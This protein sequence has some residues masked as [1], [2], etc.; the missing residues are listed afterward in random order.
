MAEPT[1][2]D[3][4]CMRTPAKN[5]QAGAV[6]PANRRYA[7]D[8]APGALGFVHDLLNT[9]SAGRPRQPDLLE[10]LDS[11]Q[12]WLDEAIAAWAVVSGIAAQRIDLDEQS[13]AALRGFRDDLHANISHSHNKSGGSTP[14]ALA[15]PGATVELSVRPDGEIA[16]Q[17]RGSGWRYVAAVALSTA[18]TGQSDGS[19]SRLKTCRNPRCQGAFYDRSRNNSGVWHDL[20]ACGMPTNTRAHRARRRDDPPTE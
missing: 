9:R 5:D 15:V 7:V 2:A 14:Q 13:R 3:H 10:H 12:A 20:Y 17:P 6:W 16:V 8:S 19:W 4:G 18:L 1:I 11:A